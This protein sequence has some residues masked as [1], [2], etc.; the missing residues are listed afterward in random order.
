MIMAM[1]D[2]PR[3]HR[4]SSQAEG[5]RDRRQTRGGSKIRAFQLDR[6]ASLDSCCGTIRRPQL[7]GSLLDSVCQ[8]IR[9]TRA[10]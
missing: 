10:I 5:E 8:I 3:A 7:R 1:T 4:F 6:S 2:Q 9:H